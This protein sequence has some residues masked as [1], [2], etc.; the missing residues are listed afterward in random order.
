MSMMKKIIFALAAFI[1][2]AAGAQ[3]QKVSDVAVSGVKLIKDG[4]TMNVDM[5]IDLS[6]LDVKNRRSVHVVPVIRNGADSLE[7]S[8]I[9][10]YSRG[11]YINYLRRGES[12]FADLGETVYKEG[13]QPA[14]INY[15]QSVPY[16]KW[17][18]GSEIY[19]S[20]RT[21]G[22]CQD[23]LAQ[24]TASVG[25]FAIP[26]YAP[27]F[28][29]VQPAPELSKERELS[30]TAY[31]DFVVSRTD[32]NPEYRNNRYEL[33]K[34]IETINSVK[35]DSDIKVKRI[36]LK[37][38]ASPESPFANNERLAKGR[39]AA[40][41]DYVKNLYNFEESMLAT[42]YD[43]ENWDGLKAYV[44]ES[45]LAGKEGILELIST[46]MDLD[47]KEAQI[48][49]QWPE[50]YRFLLDNC[51]PALRKTDYAIEY[52]IVDYTDVEKILEIFRTSPNKLSLNEL[53]VASTAFEPGSDEYAEVFE[54]A[55]KM[56]PSDPI[57]NLNAANAAI[58]VGNLKAARKYIDKAG[59]SKEAV[60]ARGLYYM[61]EGDYDKAETYLKAAGEEG[62][63]ESAQM[64][65]QCSKLRIY[66]ANNR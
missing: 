53:Y 7:L 32:I 47:K 22:C 65:E 31:I 29:Y 30:G 56:Y 58:S 15:A 6:K 48:K 51:Y 11:R 34:I 57:A 35:N 12:V 33:D 43:P 46:E 38:F 13:E 4:S 3:A 21:C 54:V 37:G 28:I 52:T 50:D 1:L 59:D 23:L 17:M 61:A 19:L 2:M 14:V 55:V 5:D 49:A 16:E 60:Y 18:D 41:K 64:L 26:V 42:S 40:L 20:R 39:T 25:A 66:H 10:V 62:I 27:Y 36:T 24:E 9:G 8:P 45:N 63:A 44:Q